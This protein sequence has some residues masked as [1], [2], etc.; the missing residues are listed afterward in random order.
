[1]ADAQ[2]DCRDLETLAREQGIRYFL[3]SFIDLS[4]AQRAKLVPATAIAAMQ[5]NGAGFAGFAAAFDFSPADPDLLAIPDPSGL[6]RLPWKPDVAWLP[7]DL[8]MRTDYVEQGPRNT[9]RRLI[10]RAQ[11]LGLTV[12]TGVECEFFLVNPDGEQVGD[13]LDNG[14]KPC[15]DASALM[16]RYDVIAEL[17]DAMQGLGWEPY[18]NDH[19]DAN[20]Q[21]EMNWKYADALVT[22][23]RH[24][25]FKFMARA[26]AEKHGLR[27]TFMPKPF[28]HLTGTG[29]HAHISLWQG[30]TNVC[31]DASDPLALSEQGYHFVGG[32]IHNAQAL[33]AILNPTVNSYKRIN[34]PRTVSGA[35]WAPNMVTY[36][37]DNRTHMIRVPGGGRFEMRL[38]DGAANPYLLQ[39]A[40]LAAGLDGI[41]NRRDPGPWQD[42]NMYTQA[43]LAQDAPRLP[44][45]LLD[46]LRALDGSATLRAMLGDG[47]VDPYVQIKTAEWNAHC[48]HLSAW[49]KHQ[50]LDC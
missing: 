48:A 33:C 50:T 24:V 35:T 45:N 19:E 18:Q 16:R 47:L 38:P 11:G 9:L 26:I 32:L 14:S 5:R 27:A 2:Q 39:A 15:Y 21:F 7:S 29:C 17:C 10:A 34:A 37:G 3:I 12:K 25:F 42:I 36:A 31:H 43:H 20:G 8:K 22:A 41:E 49:E 1:M 6:M 30:K 23:D 28:M 40:L 13:A 44:L 46:A 4:G